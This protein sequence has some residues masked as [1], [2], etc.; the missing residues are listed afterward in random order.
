MSKFTDRFKE[1]LGPEPDLDSL[2]EPTGIDRGG[3]GRILADRQRPPLDGILI[4]AQMLNLPDGIMRE[5]LEL[6]AP[7]EPAARFCAAMLHYSQGP[8]LLG[9]RSIAAP[10]SSEV[11]K[12]PLPPPDEHGIIHM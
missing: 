8:G 11:W 5:L 1:L 10:S 6:A 2:V 4:V 12:G 3:W 9:T 7:G